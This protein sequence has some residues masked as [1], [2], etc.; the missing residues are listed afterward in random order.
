[1]IQVQKNA[2]EGAQQ[3]QP[4]VSDAPFASRAEL[5]EFIKGEVTK[6]ATALP[7]PQIERRVPYGTSGPLTKDSA[8]Y[9]ILKAAAFSAGLVA[10]ED[11]KAEI[12]IH[13]KLTRIYKDGGFT[14]HSN[15]FIIP[16]GAEFLPGNSSEAERLRTEIRQKSLAGVVGADPDEMHWLRGRSVSKA[17]GT[18][19]NALGGSLVDYPTMGEVIDMQRNRE[20]LTNAGCNEI[21]L[22][23]SGRLSFPKLT[24]GS[25]AYWIGEGT[26]ITGSDPATGNLELIAKKLAILVTMN[27]ELVRFGS[28]SAEALIRNDMARVAALRSD[29]AQL[30][31]TGGTQIKG[32][33]TY[34][35]ITTHV[36]ATVGTNGNTF[37]AADVALM[38]SKLPDAVDHATAW[39]MRRTLMAALMNRRADAVSAAD[40]KGA[41]L[42]SSSR[43]RASAGPEQDLYG[44][45]VV[46]SNQISNT[47]TK[48][49]GVDLTYVLLGYFPDWVVARMGIME[50]TMSS[51]SDTAMAN[52]QT[53][54]RGIQHVDAGPRNPAS[55]I[56]CDTLLNT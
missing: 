3:S 53:L 33:L 47:R 1:M 40:G 43:G 11:C 16:F 22:P 32:L 2:S 42:W 5:V 8:G 30:E 20:A 25:T 37:E 12:D 31:G 18:L 36:A 55:F 38:E 27:N 6:A 13:K 29:L 51:T 52:D 17:L 19:T 56:L 4:P 54:L 7:Q 35:G 45:K 15:T 46:R 34:S 28:P 24:G 14:P 10:A 9:S 50:F 44:T 49:S 41:F 39:L 23:P 26:T 21:A 48:G